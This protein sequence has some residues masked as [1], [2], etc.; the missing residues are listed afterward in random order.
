MIMIFEQ[1]YLNYGM[2]LLAINFHELENKI[3]NPFQ[4][5]EVNPD[6][7]TF[8]I[9][10]DNHHYNERFY[11]HIVNSPCCIEDEF[12]Q[13]LANENINDNVLSLFHMNMCSIPGKWNKFCTYLNTLKIKFHIIGLSE[14]WLKPQNEDIYNIDAYNLI[15]KSRNNTR[16]GGIALFICDQYEIS[17]HHDLSEFCEE[18]ETQFVEINSPTHNGK[19]MIGLVYRIPNTDPDKFYN[20]ISNTLQIIDNEK[21]MCYIMGDFNLN[22]LNKDT[23]NKTADFLEIL[24]SHSYLPMINRPTRVRTESAILIDNIFSN[25]FSHL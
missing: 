10:P 2:M 24:F 6:D 12:N 23:H 22:L 9:D 20:Y 13:M 19:T 15:T 3:F 25:A 5:N 18:Y 14:T 17:E 8:D 11:Q 16:G 21:K 1:P 7:P 4:I